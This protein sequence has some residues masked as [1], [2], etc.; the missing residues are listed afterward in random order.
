MWQRS[1]RRISR[2]KADYDSL[3]LRDE[4][5]PASLLVYSLSLVE[6]AEADFA[7]L[8]RECRAR[9]RP[10]YDGACFHAEQ[11][12]EK[13]LKARLCEVGATL[14]KIH[15]LV[16]LLEDTYRALV[17]SIPNG[18]GVSVRL[19]DTPVHRPREKTP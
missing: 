14:A 6:K 3:K 11:C 17:G 8:E 2:F 7:T 12:A 4:F 10:N 5:G 13:Y 15:D 18:S 1:A 16:A 9:K 19:C